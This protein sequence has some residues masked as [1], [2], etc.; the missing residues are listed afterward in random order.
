MT[1]VIE[2]KGPIRD[3]IAK[4]SSTLHKEILLSCENGLSS[5]DDYVEIVILKTSKGITKFALNGKEKITNSL[6]LSMNYYVSTEEYELAA[7]ARDCIKSWI[8]RG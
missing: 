6:N 4:N 5:N 3:W 1:N 7:R 2:V 8:E